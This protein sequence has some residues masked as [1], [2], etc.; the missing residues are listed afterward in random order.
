MIRTKVMFLCTGNSARSQMAEGWLRHLTDERVQSL[1][2]GLS[3]KGLNPLSVRVMQEVGID[4]S[5]QRST[6]VVGYLGQPVQFVIT[7]CDNA[8]EKCPIFPFAF[9]Y[10]HWSISDPAAVEDPAERLIAFRSARD[11][12][13]EFIETELLLLLPRKGSLA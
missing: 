7:V 9:K 4:I 12:L 1:S 5:Q 10:L 6:D 2:A 3:P 13:R 11:Q 8:H